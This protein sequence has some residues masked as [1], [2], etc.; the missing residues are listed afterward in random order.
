MVQT[1]LPYRRVLQLGTLPD[2]AVVA[3][4]GEKA[5]QQNALESGELRAGLLQLPALFFIIW[6]HY[7]LLIALPGEN[8]LAFACR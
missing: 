1:L 4:E 5:F 8:I 7:F 6:L 2:Q 3:V